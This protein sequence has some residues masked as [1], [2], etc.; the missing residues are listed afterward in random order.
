[1]KRTK[2]KTVRSFTINRKW[3]QR[4]KAVGS[5][6]DPETGKQCCL[7]FYTR[8]CGLSKWEINDNG[9]PSEPL[10]TRLNNS[11]DPDDVDKFLA[12]LPKPLRELVTRHYDESYPYL[13]DSGISKN[14]A[15]VNDD[16]L[17]DAE[18]REEMIRSRF[19][20]IGVKVRFIG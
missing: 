6:R 3:W 12:S 1:M 9:L 19:A 20:Q 8:A 7:G 13:T 2:L 4:G 18:S 5:L 10:T 11:D 15:S 17:L 14:L 16:S